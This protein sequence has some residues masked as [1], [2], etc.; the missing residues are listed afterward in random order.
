MFLI[1]RT[2]VLP[3]RGTVHWHMTCVHVTG[4]IQLPAPDS[5]LFPFSF[6]SPAG[7][8]PLHPLHPLHPRGLRAAGRRQ[9]KTGKS[10]KLMRE[11]MAA[12]S[13]W[14][15]LVLHTFSVL[16]LFS[17]LSRTWEFPYKRIVLSASPLSHSCAIPN[18]RPHVPRAGIPDDHKIAQLDDSF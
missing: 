16:N 1:R 17:F 6:I 13:R 8:L 10:L 14:K 15:I 11:R 12:S 4:G 3:S 7:Q 9:P 5:F 18:L 2:V